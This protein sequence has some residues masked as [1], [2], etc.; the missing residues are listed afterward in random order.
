VISAN[1]DLGLWMSALPV[2]L[3]AATFTWLLSIPMRNVSI[4]DSLWSLM[5]FA[6][7]VIYGLAADPRAPRLS[8]VLWML[9]L[10]AFRLSF[11][12]TRRNVGKGEDHRYQAIRARNAPGFTW[13][14]LYLVFW[15]Q[16]LL[17]WI[18]SLP[19]LGAFSS[20]RPLGVLDGLG[21]A[22]WLVGFAFE[23][24]GDW[25]LARFRKNPAN[26][27]KVMDRGLWR[28]TRH[29]N[30]FGEFCIWWGF[31]LIALSAGAWW[32][33]A[34]PLLITWLLLKVSGVSLLERDIGNRRP[35]YADYVLKTNAF[36]PGPPR[37]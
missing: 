36:F 21:L 34:G 31:W 8:F 22:L 32:A 2:L 7:G 14:S 4:V 30:Y 11:H 12:I 29:P 24:A 19:I 17:A 23:A 27:G 13:K 18:I 33:V 9:V 28:F 10:W 37:N 3:V 15:L 25:Q 20:T 6:A 35:Q 16:A 26:A 5:F 1:F